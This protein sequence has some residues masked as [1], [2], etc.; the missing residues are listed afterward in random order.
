[1]KLKFHGQH[2]LSQMSIGLL[3]SKINHGELYILVFIPLIDYTTSVRLIILKRSQ[4][5]LEE[6]IMITFRIYQNNYWANETK[7]YLVTGRDIV[8]LSKFK[9]PNGPLKFN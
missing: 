7:L 3:K 5:A 4:D 1:M 6:Q 2:I 8:P 9:Y